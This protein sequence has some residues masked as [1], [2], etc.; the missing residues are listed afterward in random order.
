MPEVFGIQRLRGAFPILGGT[1]TVDDRI[2]EQFIPRKAQ[3]VVCE[4]IAVP[5]VM[6]A[7]PDVFQGAD[8]TWFIDNEAACSSVIRGASRHGDIASLAALTHL[9]VFRCDCRL[10]FEWIDSDSNPADGFSR[11]G[12]H[13]PWTIQHR[14]LL[15]ELAPF[16]WEQLSEQ[17]G[18]PL[19]IFLTLG[20]SPDP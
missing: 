10:W 17:Q 8:V 2:L 20:C 18:E 9:A 11:K 19:V 16:T 6:A 1:S 12:I 14:W 5:Q 4:G 13:D 3:I 15:E 7:Y